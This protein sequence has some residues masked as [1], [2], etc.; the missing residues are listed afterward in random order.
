[1]RARALT[2]TIAAARLATLGAEEAAAAD[3]RDSSLV[4][5]DP[6]SLAEHWCC[7]EHAADERG[8]LDENNDVRHCNDPKFQS[9]HG[10][11]FYAVH[12]FAK[13]ES[14]WLNAFMEAWWIGTTNG[15]DHKLHFLRPPTTV[16]YFVPQESCRLLP[17]E[18]ECADAGCAW[19]GSLCS[20]GTEFSWGVVWNELSMLSREQPPEPPDRGAAAP[21]PLGAG[22]YAVGGGGRQEEAFA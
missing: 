5:A 20:A 15:Y 13:D 1:M 22:A 17:S 4:S 6:D 9:N 2:S 16:P 7:R 21:R 10:P 14:A 12:K 19:A 11:A 18:K 8:V 3:A